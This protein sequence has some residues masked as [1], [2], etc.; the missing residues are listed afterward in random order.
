M[1]NGIASVSLQLSAYEEATQGLPLPDGG[2]VDAVWM[3]VGRVRFQPGTSCTGDDNE[4]DIQGP[5]IADLVSRGVIPQVPKLS[6][7]PGSVCR[8][9]LEYNKVDPKAVPAG[10]PA[11]IAD[12]SILIQGSRGDGVPF[13]VTSRVGDQVD[14]SSKN[15]AFPVNS[16]Q[17]PLFLAY[18]ITPW[19]TAL[20][21][22]S[23]KGP[24][25]E[26]NDQVNKDRLDAFESALK[27]SARLFRD[28]NGDGKLD[29]QETQ[30]EHQL[31]N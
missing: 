15:G 25:I 14:L 27:Q 9:R 30:S 17:N 20:D 28:E 12:A 13:T 23:L 5:L 16:G 1:G 24:S 29:T 19:I 6:Q 18:E 10:A 31:T 3:A 4:V 22:S 2:H 8:F 7:V 21:L 11:G 26:V